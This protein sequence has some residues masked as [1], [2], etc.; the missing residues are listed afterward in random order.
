ML[1]CY[2]YKKMSKY[3]Y[4]WL[5]L[6]SY[7]YC[8]RAERKKARRPFNFDRLTSLLSSGK[9]PCIWYHI[10][11]CLKQINL[12]FLVESNEDT[13]LCPVCGSGM[14]LYDHRKRIMKQY[15]QDDEYVIVPRYRCLKNIGGL[16]RESFQILNQYRK[17]F[18]DSTKI[19]LAR[20]TRDL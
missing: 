1:Q 11:S 9:K 2:A 7:L 18:S 15:D 16:G 12:V 6:N 5:S 10:V 4:C 14:K 13:P 19:I 20:T 3:E 17:H 8:L